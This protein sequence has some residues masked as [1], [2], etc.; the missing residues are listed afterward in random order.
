LKANISHLFAGS[1][2]GK[3]FE[4]NSTTKDGK[5]FLREKFLKSFHIFLSKKFFE[6]NI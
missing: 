3:L 1:S 2:N 6:E 4:Q 5:G